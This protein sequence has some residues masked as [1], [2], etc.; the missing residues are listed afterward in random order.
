M[1]N[2]DQF[3]LKKG[4]HYYFGN[5]LSYFRYPDDELMDTG[6]PFFGA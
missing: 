4:F 6:L 2:I 1:T 3:S 5:D